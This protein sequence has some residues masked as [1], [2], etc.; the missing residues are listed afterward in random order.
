[1]SKR[2]Q[3]EQLGKE[4][5]FNYFVKYLKAVKTKGSENF[6]ISEKILIDSERNTKVFYKELVSLFLF[7]MD[8]YAEIPFEKIDEIIKH[9]NDTY[10]DPNEIVT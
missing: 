2:K 5:A 6:D 10:E 8:L 9:M 7:Y 1:M 4:R 3:S